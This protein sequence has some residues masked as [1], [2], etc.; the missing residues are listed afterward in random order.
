MSGAQTYASVV[1]GYSGLHG[2][3]RERA[4]QLGSDD[5]ADLCFYQGQ[6]AAAALVVD[7]QIV[8]AAQ[9]ER[10]SRKKFD[11]DFPA[12]AIDWCLGHACIDARDI[13]SVA[14]GFD[15]RKHAQWANGSVRARELY[16]R[17]YDPARQISLVRERLPGLSADVDVTPVRHH[18]AHAHAA[19]SAAEYE[20]AAVLVVDGMGELEAI[21][22]FRW[23]Q[24]LLQP[25]RSLGPQSSLGLFYSMITRHLGFLPASDEYKV[26]GL[27]PYG[28][29][30]RFASVMDRALEITPRGVRVPILN[31][32]DGEAR[33]VRTASWLANEL[34]A[35]R[36][37]QAPLMQHHKDI[38]AAAQQR[39]TLALGHL[40]KVAVALAGR[41][42]LVLA[43]GVA[44]N[45]SAIGSLA[46]RCE[47]ADAVYVPPAPSDE[48]TAIGSAMAVCPATAERCWPRLPLLGPSV[49]WS[50]TKPAPHARLSG[51]S[52]IEF[53]AGLLA[54]GAIVGWAQ[55]RMEF[56]PRA[57]G[58]RSILA[59]PS[60]VELRDR[61]NAIVKQR[62]E[63]RPLAPAVMAEHADDWFH[64]PIDVNVRHMTTT[65]KVRAEKMALVAGIVHVDGTARIQAVHR[66]EHEL[67]WS[68]LAAFA[69]KVGIPM[70]LNTSLNLRGEPIARTGDD[71]LR[72]FRGSDLDAVVIGEDIWLSERWHDPRS[73][74][75][76]ARQAL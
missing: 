1:L 43:G 40:A 2:A 17:V 59:M 21:S 13:T 29:P 41:P 4:R 53:V 58:N 38:A 67:L 32:D 73:R 5:P 37:P 62:E 60:S 65:V 7:G 27:A 45:C 14:H 18:V 55:D 49:T 63:F 61:I 31:W 42:R 6:D 70:L 71:A 25:L 16:E 36:D 66:D 75:V 22:I 44:L 52:L 46:A 39:L 72:V 19:V 9:Q 54:D 11:G 24:G 30:E 12:D 10:F 35:A 57:L 56:G 23:E 48:G 51:P 64:V 76:A 69:G 3:A 26:M 33:Y 8:A 47:E 15:Y 68:V 20:S 74:T 28:D 50:L 34:G